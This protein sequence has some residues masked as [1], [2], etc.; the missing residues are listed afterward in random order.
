MGAPIEEAGPPVDAPVWLRAPLLSVSKA[1]VEGE[2][3]AVDRFGNLITS[4]PA[5]AL[6]AGPLSIS[7]AG[8]AAGPLRRSYSEA[9]VGALT[10]VIGS[11]GRLEVAVNLGSA[12]ERLGLR[13]RGARVLVTREGADV[14]PG[15]E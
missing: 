9:E 2:V 3:I 15:E 10:A 12:A 7:I 6:P 5:G 4:I 14:D 1:A 8:A 13:S 11:S